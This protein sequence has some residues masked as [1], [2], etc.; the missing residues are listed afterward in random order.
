MFRS[1]RM[2][3]WANN[4]S[5]CTHTFVYGGLFPTS[6]T[7]IMSVVYYISCMKCIF[8]CFFFFISIHSV[9]NDA[10]S[11]RTT[12]VEWLPLSHKALGAICVCVRMRANDASHAY[13]SCSSKLQA[14]K[15][16]GST[17][18]IAIVTIRSCIFYFCILF[19]ASDFH[20][21]VSNGF[22]DDCSD[23]RWKFS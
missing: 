16:G 3:W 7:S 15:G 14:A 8:R 10:P 12:Y 9:S 2:S 21:K 4:C 19:L 17:L 5:M 13:N 11:T 22:R 6:N 20:I 23:P 1:V 18:H